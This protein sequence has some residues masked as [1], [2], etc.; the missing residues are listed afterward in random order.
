[1]TLIAP[2]RPLQLCADGGYQLRLGVLGV[3]LIMVPD[4]SQRVS[5]PAV[6]NCPVAKFSIASILLSQCG[7]LSMYSC[8]CQCP[9]IS[10]DTASSSSS[11]LSRSKPRCCVLHCSRFHL[12]LGI[13]RLYATHLDT[14]AAK[15]HIAHTHMILN[16]TSMCSHIQNKK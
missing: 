6:F 16:S 13:D 7:I 5:Q 1:M 3:P 10:S 9:Y 2:I 15:R 8:T 4:R 11:T 12:H 14:N